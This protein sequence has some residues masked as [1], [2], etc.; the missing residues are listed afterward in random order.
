V[1]F[2]EGWCDQAPQLARAIG[3]SDARSATLT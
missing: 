3:F 1:E 2:V